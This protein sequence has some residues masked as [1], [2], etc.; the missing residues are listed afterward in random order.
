MTTIFPRTALK[1]AAIPLARNACAIFI[2]RSCL[3]LG[4]NLPKYG[5]ITPSMSPRLMVL[6]TNFPTNSI[7]SRTSFFSCLVSSATSWYRRS[8]ATGTCLMLLGLSSSTGMV[9]FLLGGISFYDFSVQPVVPFRIRQGI[10]LVLWFRTVLP[11]PLTGQSPLLHHLFQ[12][13]AV[14]RESLGKIDHPAE[15]RAEQYPV[16]VGEVPVYL[17][18]CSTAERKEVQQ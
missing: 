4:R 10:V 8:L 15:Q 17:Y 16:V 9:C 18:R 11:L 14:H 7:M 1:T 2:A 3:T 13:H 6:A 5:I 12:I